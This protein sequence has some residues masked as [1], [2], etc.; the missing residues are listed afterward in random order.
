MSYQRNED[1]S[2]TISATLRADEWTAFNLA[3]G[4]FMADA[5]RLDMSVFWTLVSVM[6]RLQDGNPNYQAYEIPADRRQPFKYQHVQVIEIP[7]PPK[8]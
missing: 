1:G 7:E 5:E 8:Q 6:N 4:Y 2:V 3:W